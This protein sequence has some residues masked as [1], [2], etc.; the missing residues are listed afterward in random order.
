MTT[1]A[2]AWETVVGLEVHTELRTLTKL[3]C[4]CRNEFGSEPNTNVC[5][6][7]MGL[8]GS[9]PVLNRYAVELAMR[10]GSALRCSVSARGIPSH[11]SNE[12]Q[13]STAS[14]APLV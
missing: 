1:I 12:Q 9:L 3:F 10:I 7:C 5:A 13:A 6:T 2:T 14:G 8:P 4:G 11:S